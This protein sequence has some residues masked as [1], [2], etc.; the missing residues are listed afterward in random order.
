MK[1]RGENTKEN[2]M[3]ELDRFTR[4][5]LEKV[6]IDF[7]D[8][9]YLGEAKEQALVLCLDIRGFSKF[10]RDNDEQVVF[11]LITSFTSNLLSCINQFAYGCS[12]YK[13]LGDG[14]LVIWDEFNDQALKEAVSVFTTYSEFSNEEFFTEFP[15]MGLAGALVLDKV[16]KY[17]ISAEASQLKYRDYVGYAINLASRLEGVANKD[18]LV[19][20][21]KLAD[22]KKLKIK[23]NDSDDMKTTLSLLKGLRAEDQEHAYFFDGFED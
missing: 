9:N 8:G 23:I 7:F 12:Y 5:G 3:V 20:N 21:K 18:E 14:V 17:E 22:T 11:K 6:P 1:D 2:I 15:S 4:A 19:V 10:F 16:F 13:L